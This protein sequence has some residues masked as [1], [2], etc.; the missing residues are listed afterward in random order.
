[1]TAALENAAWT[2]ILA[3][4][5]DFSSAIFDGATRTDPHRIAEGTLIHMS[6]M[7][8]VLEEI[9]HRFEGRIG[10][11]DMMICNDPYGGN[12]RVG[13]VVIAAPVFAGGELRARQ[14]DGQGA[15]PATSER[16][17]HQHAVPR[18]GTV[19]GQ[20]A[21]TLLAEDLR[22]RPLPG[23]R[24]RHDPGQLALTRPACSATCSPS[25]ALSVSGSAP[26]GDHGWA[27]PRVSEEVHGR[28]QALRVQAGRRR[29]QHVGATVRTSES[30][31]STP[32]ATAPRTS[33]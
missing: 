15:S 33:T 31:G 28:D 26:C 32:T 5:R 30:R 23:R 17:A 24:L 25:R 13:D 1:M 3:L 8:V 11:G 7:H 21:L 16:L 6:G 20:R 9:A 2:S 18:Y 29:D 22:P 4:A 12:S 10:D 27:G 19:F 14:A